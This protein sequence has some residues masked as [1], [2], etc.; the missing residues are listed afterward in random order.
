[1]Y[2]LRVS[3]MHTMYFDHTTNSLF[4]LFQDPVT[5]FLSQFHDLF[6]KYNQMSPISVSHVCMGAE[7]SPEV[8]QSTRGHIPKENWLPN[9]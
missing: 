6:L 9:P 4:Q 7:H 2:P 8:N 1:M 5:M 3:H